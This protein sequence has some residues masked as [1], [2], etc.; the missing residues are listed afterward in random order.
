MPARLAYCRTFQLGTLLPVMHYIGNSYIQFLE[1]L[2]GDV[3]VHQILFY[4]LLKGT[5]KM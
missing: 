3:Q 5:H 4:Y 2:E 1:L